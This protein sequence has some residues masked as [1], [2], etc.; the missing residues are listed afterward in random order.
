MKKPEAMV[1]GFQF[2][3]RSIFF[4]TA[5]I[6]H[7]NAYAEKITVM[8]WLEV[9]LRLQNKTQLRPKYGGKSDV[10]RK[11]ARDT[12]AALLLHRRNFKKYIA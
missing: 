4:L 7:E 6:K 2:C 1:S 8:F 11:S 10:S 5:R 3:V 12:I 9:V